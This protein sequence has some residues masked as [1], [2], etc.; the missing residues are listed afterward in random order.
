MA[1]GGNKGKKRTGAVLTVFSGLS[2][3]GCAIYCI[4]WW[5]K[6]T[7]PTLLIPDVA[8]PCWLYCGTLRPVWGGVAVLSGM[9]LMLAGAAGRASGAG[10]YQTPGGGEYRWVTNGAGGFHDDPRA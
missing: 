8:L 9:L 7:A 5:P 6:P 3:L 4:V 1:K 2:V 10:E